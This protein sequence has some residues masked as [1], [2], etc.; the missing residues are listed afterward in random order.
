MAFH[1]IYLMAVDWDQ[2]AIATR[3][4]YQARKALGMEATQGGAHETVVRVHEGNPVVIGNASTDGVLVLARKPLDEAGSALTYA[5]DPT[6][7]E[8]LSGKP[9]LTLA[10][11]GLEQ[12]ED[13][14]VGRKDPDPSAVTYAPEIYET[15]MLLLTAANGNPFYALSLA[16]GLA[17]TTGQASFKDVQAA[18]L[19]VFPANDPVAAALVQKILDATD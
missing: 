17:R 18:I 7:E 9:K 11:A 16:G 19:K 12:R 1:S 4:V 6:P 3:A 5:V 10:E 14:L 8:V 13:H 2:R 15:T